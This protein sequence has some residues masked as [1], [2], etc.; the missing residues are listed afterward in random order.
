MLTLK[1]SSKFF[2]VPK[3]GGTF[4]KR[5][6][7]HCA[8]KIGHVGP[9]FTCYQAKNRGFFG[10]KMACVVRPPDD[11]VRSFYVYRRRHRGR[12][13]TWDW[14][15]YLDRACSDDD[16]NTFAIKMLNCNCDTWV[17][18][19]YRDF[20]HEGVHVMAMEKLDEQLLQT[21]DMF[22]EEY[23]L[24]KFKEMERQNVNPYQDFD[25]TWDEGV[26]K[27]IVARNQWAQDIWE[28]AMEWDGKEPNC[29]ELWSDNQYDK[30]VNHPLTPYIQQ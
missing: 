23:D 13:Y 4:M 29:P 30:H 12:G 20:V 24:A 25:T 21:L 5:A 7:V 28:Q 14:S 2:H 27:E 18:C 1:N 26:R 16:F 9:H 17:N 19:R 10:G 3:C 22:E 8:T 11:W 15:W 6:L